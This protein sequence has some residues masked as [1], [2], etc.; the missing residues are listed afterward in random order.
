MESSPNKTKPLRATPNVSTVRAARIAFCVLFVVL[1]AGVFRLSVVADPSRLVAS[2]SDR[3]SAFVD[4]LEKFP[5]EQKQLLV[6]TEGQVL[7]PAYLQRYADA[8]RAVSTLDNVEFVGSLFSPPTLASALSRI[9]KEPDS[10]VESGLVDDVK[11]LLRQ[12]D[13][14]PS[15][16]VSGSLDAAQMS[17]TLGDNDA[18]EHTIQAVKAELESA[19]P[20]ESGIRWSLAGNPM[21]E[22]AIERDVLREILRVTLLAAVLGTLVAVVMLRDAKSVALLVSVPTAAVLATLG[23]LGWLG[24]SL[25]L[26][27]QAVMVVVFL[28]VFSDTLHTLNTDRSRRSLVLACGLTSLT[29]AGAAIA[30]WFASAAVIQNF[31]VSLLLGIG[32]GF[33]VWILWLFAWGE[34]ETSQAPK[35]QPEP[36]LDWLAASRLSA[37]T[38]WVMACLSLTVLLLLGTQLRTG[39]SLTE[40]LPQSHELRSSLALA[41]EKFSGYLPLQVVVSANDSTVGVD[42]FVTDVAQLQKTLNDAEKDLHWYSLVDVL[43]L[44]PGQTYEERLS[45]LPPPLLST[46]WTPDQ[47]VVLFAP[48]SLTE[49]LQTPTGSVEHLDSTLQQIAADSDVSVGPVTGMPVLVREAS[50]ALLGDAWRGVFLTVLVLSLL[51][52]AVLRSVRLA[53]LAGLPVVFGLAAYY[54]ALVLLGEP[55]RHA[56][57]VMMTVVI[58]LSVDNALHLIVSVQSDP[59]DKKRVMNDCLAVLHRVTLV[60]MAGFMALAFSDIPSLS[61]LGMAASVALAAGFAV[62]VLSLPASLLKGL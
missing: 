23:L 40:N 20:A 27:S 8:V 38:R 33:S 31:A 12:A 53:W 24:L 19:Y 44:A 34:S 25:T 21:V 9:I 54:A 15:R 35:L 17:I 51:V 4:R 58:G 57:V 39:F 7:D 18:I 32:V 3:Y 41:D 60:T 49:W 45:L 59:A 37:K 50:D 22:Q 6:F 62:S 43:A 5:A 14:I 36:E 10:S 30:L 52:L 2:N 1:F 26:L 13:F 42:P 16:M 56:G 55:L 28:V 48:Q 47:Q 11:A 29:T 46:L 61:V